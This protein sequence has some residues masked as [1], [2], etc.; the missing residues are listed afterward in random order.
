MTTWDNLDVLFVV[1]AFLFQ[2]VLIVHFA[3]RKW[4]F[5]IVQK[6]GWLVYALGA[7]AAVI[8]ILLLLGGKA[9]WLWFAGFLLLAWGILGC[10][11][12]YVKKIEW[13][14]PMRWSVFAPYLILYLAAL[15]F[16][17][18]SLY[19]ISLPLW[20]AYAVLYAVSTVLNITSH[21]VSG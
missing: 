7:P 16:Y 11:V 5:S 21:K 2:I 20:F 3:L 8:S 6:Y 13:R 17:W 14:S 9:W 18:W 15:M 10:T 19:R 1:W 12:E 4:R